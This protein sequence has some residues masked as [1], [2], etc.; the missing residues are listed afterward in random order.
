MVQRISCTGGSPARHGR[1]PGGGAGARGWRAG[2]GPRGGSGQAGKPSLSDARWAATMIPHCETGSSSPSS[3][4]K[5]PATPVCARSPR[6]RGRTSRPSSRAAEGRHSPV[7]WDRCA[8]GAADD[9]HKQDMNKLRK[10]SRAAFDRA[11]LDVFSSHH[12]AAI[13]IT[14]VAMTGVAMT[15]SAGGLAATLQKQIHDGQLPQVAKMN[16]LRAAS[17]EKEPTT[18]GSL[19]P[20]ARRRRAAARP[21]PSSTPLVSRWQ[22]GAPAKPP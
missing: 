15:D 17:G 7:G 14:G 20:A 6:S 8:R 22:H 21:V 12:M 13:M 4:C 18:A 16:A 2:H 10:L 1:G 5:S 3:P 11:W 19:L 9:V